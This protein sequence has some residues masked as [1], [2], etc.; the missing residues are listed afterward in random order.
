[1]M[2][3]EQKHG[4]KTVEKAIDSS[5]YR[6]DKYSPH[7]Y[8]QANMNVTTKIAIE[9]VE[10]AVALLKRNIDRRHNETRKRGGTFHAVN[11]ECDYL[12]EEIITKKILRAYPGHIILSEE[13]SSSVNYINE[14]NLWVV[15]PID[16]TKGFAAGLL[17]YSVSLSYLYGQQLVSS[18]L[19]LASTN[20]I[21]W[22][23]TGK[24]AYIGMR[25]L[26]VDDRPAKRA[27]LALDPSNKK[28]EVAM[29]ELAPDLS[30]GVR[31][32]QMTSGGAGPLGLIARGNLQGLVF[33][34][35]S[36][37]DYSAGVHLVL[38]AGGLVTDFQG[39]PYQ[40]FSRAGIVACTRSVQPYILRYTKK[41]AKHFLS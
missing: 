15:D 2:T 36:I 37:W 29:R 17:T 14:K 27:M 26:H 41:V 16:G 30:L 13:T 23:E 31:F 20:E 9:A 33:A 21:L 12:S 7:E 22:A 28:R 24:G 18:A 5:R 11:T 39:K 4:I 35:P 1:M 40:L 6:L 8:T 19:Y 38:E 25:R 34:Y 32:L 10:G 3:K